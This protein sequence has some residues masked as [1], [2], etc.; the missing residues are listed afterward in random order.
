MSEFS[1]LMSKQTHALEMSRKNIHSRGW[2]Y[3]AILQDA[4]SVGL[5]IAETCS[6]IH[7]EVK[8]LLNLRNSNISDNLQKISELFLTL[9]EKHVESKRFHQ[10]LGNSNFNVSIKNFDELNQKCNVLML[11]TIFIQLETTKSLERAELNYNKQVSPDVI[12][13][14]R[15]IKK[16]CLGVKALISLKYFLRAW[17]SMTSDIQIGL[18]SLINALEQQPQKHPPPLVCRP[19]VQPHA[20]TF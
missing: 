6:E 5:K 20:P 3:Y 1:N 18:P 19:N 14:F 16:L 13:G 10:W 12:C 9:F 7:K 8:C 17:D 11:Y 2:E 4:T 15:N